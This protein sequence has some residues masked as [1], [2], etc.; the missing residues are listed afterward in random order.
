MFARGFGWLRRFAR[1]FGVQQSEALRDPD[2]AR[3]LFQRRY[4]ALRLL[5]AANTKALETMASMERAAAQPTPFGMPFV[6]SHCT[7]VVVSTFKMVHNLD[8]L[9]P[10]KYTRLFDRLQ[11]IQERIDHE[12]AG[13]RLPSDTP[14]ILPMTAIDSRS[15]DITGAKMAN[16]GEVANIVGLRIPRGF[17]ITAAAYERLFSANDLQPE[18]DR[19]LLAHDTERLDELFALSSELQNTILAARVPEEIAEAIENAASTLAEPGTGIT[20]A[21]RSSA[22]GEDTAKTSFAG[23]YQSLLNVRRSHLLPSYLEVVA[24]KYTPQAMHY[25]L[26]RGLRDQDIAMSVGCLEMVDARCGGVAYTGNPGHREDRNVYISSTWGLPKAIVDGRSASDM[27]VVDRSEPPAIL[28]RSTGNK[29]HQFIL[30]RREGVDREELPPERRLSPSLTDEEAIAVAELALRLDRHFGV[31]VD[32]EW[33]INRDD[34]I[35]ILQCRSLA[36]SGFADRRPPPPADAPLPLPLVDGGISASPGAAAGP[37]H[38]VRREADA[39]V[40]PDGAVLVVDQPLPRWAALLARVSAV[41]AEQG[42]I[43]G[44]LATVARE[45]GVPALL[46]TGPVDT[47][48]EGLIVTVDAS[49]HR[50]YPGRIEPLLEVS[51]REEAV[52][53]TPVRKTLRNALQ[54][55]APLNLLDPDSV[56][57]K[58]SN[59]QTLHDITRLCHEQA[60]REIFAFGTTARFPEYASKQLYYNVPMQWWVLDLGGGVREP[61]RGKYVRL[62]DI[63]CAPMLALWDGMVAVPWDGPP[64]TTG[65][66]FASILFE[67]TTNPAL[68]T[69][70]RRPYAVRNYFIISEHFVNLQSR[71]GFHLTNVEG[72]AGFRPEENYLSF[73]FKG[74][75]ADIDRKTARARLIGHLLADVGFETR[76][77]EDVVTARRTNLDAAEVERGLRII[78]YLLIHTRQL[79]MIMDNRSAVEHY[80]TKMSSDIASLEGKT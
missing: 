33:A 71:F 38:C 11:D 19:L 46:G 18:I 79:D 59:C 45:L 31:A 51:S 68:A 1:W 8:T 56:D 69:P 32:V 13:Q 42:G 47:L 7:A 21:L 67:A 36:Q 49:R 17:V 29:T 74:G 4:H 34:E 27:V 62:A 24:S 41:V 48:T 44:H 55:I 10:E 70:F 39:L 75:A 30:H 53:E 20:F 58:P 37:V 63:A 76:I 61:V 23:Q 2:A 54:H 40:C 43:A 57:F 73:S 50:V 60:V 5:L 9:A 28:D 77:T 52:V 3:E 22:L 66:G 15:F 26:Q 6:R 72:L 35:V 12:L 14:L 64:A 25:R 16:L 65:R 78:G 80:R